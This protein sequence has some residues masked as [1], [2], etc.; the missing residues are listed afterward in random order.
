MYNNNKAQQSKNRVHIS[1]DILYISVRY[2]DGVFPLHYSGVIM[3][4]TASQITGV[5]NSPHKELAT[6]KMFPLDDVV[7]RTVLTLPG[8]TNDESTFVVMI[9]CRD[10]TN[11][12][13]ANIDQDVWRHMVS[14]GKK[15][16]KSAVLYITIELEIIGY[17]ISR[18][19]L[20]AYTYH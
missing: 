6:R 11:L 16:I 17:F 2:L 13:W 4:A 5:T 1:W 3:N 14:L 9:R 20:R 12:T 10:A 7:M 19:N 15:I 8:L 18:Y